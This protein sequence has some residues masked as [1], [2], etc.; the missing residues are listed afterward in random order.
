MADAASQAKV[1]ARFCAATPYPYG[2]TIGA[3]SRA[4]GAI[5]AITAVVAGG[6]VTGYVYQTI[7]GE[8]Y[9]V[10]INDDGTHDLP[11]RIGGASEALPDDGTAKSYACAAPTP[12]PRA[13][14]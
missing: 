3:A 9:G 14:P 5:R 8:S 12:A 2:G 6:R 10:R 13:T 7:G 1:V 4:S 11:A